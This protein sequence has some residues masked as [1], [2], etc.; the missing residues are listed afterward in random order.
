MS[1][2]P[3]YILPE[4]KAVERNAAIRELLQHLIYVGAIQDQ[5]EEPILDALIQ[6]ENILTT[7]IGLAVA[8]PH[9][10]SKAVTKKIVILGKSK[11]GIDF[12]SVDGN[13]VKE[14]YL[15]ISPIPE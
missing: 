6:R 14:I 11:K 7:G 1:F 13:L 15:M 2:S 9:V 5:F 12:S 10:S 8:L 3:D 4:V